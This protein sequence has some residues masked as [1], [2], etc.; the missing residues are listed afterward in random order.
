M[1]NSY[2]VGN[3]YGYLCPRCCKGDSLYIIALVTTAL[4]PN[5]CDTTDSDT[6][7]FDNSP[8]WCGCG[9]KGTTGQ[10]TVIDLLERPA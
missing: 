9:W 1:E 6:E 5:G 8:A 7:W 4:L 2:D 10:F 3:Q